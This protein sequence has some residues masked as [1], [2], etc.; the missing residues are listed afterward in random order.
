MKVLLIN[1]PDTA[2]KY[3]FIGLVAPPLGIGYIAAVLEE[4][5]IEVKIIDGSALEMSWEELE[6]EIYT[7]S[8]N[9][10]G[11][12]ALTPT[13]NQALKTARIAK[14]TCNDALV[15][16]GG[17][18]PTFTYN[19]LLKNDFVDI[20]AFGE[21]EYTM[22]ELAKAVENE[23]DLREVK[24]IATKEFVTPSRP[25]IEDL[26]ELPFPARHLLPMDKYKILN[27]KL[28]TGTL[29]SGRGCPHKCSFCS[30]AA[31]HGHKL[32]M[33]SSENIV[34]E[35]E[36]LLNVHD[37]EMMAFMDDTFTMNRKRV[38]EVCA[39]IKERD[40]DFY[41]GCTARA[42]TLNKNLLRKNEGFRMHYSIFRSRI[43]RSA[44][45]R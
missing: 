29:I 40:L 35:M 36:H 28:T 31:M 7:Y 19:E 6:K 33:R 1:P 12:T 38:E 22:L 24:G 15:V 2:S 39:E 21:G 26:D 10:I 30:S 44:T 14:N 41:W 45:F 43:C 37:A 3:K 13:I 20:V 17:Y 42:D 18:H 23:T 11:I 25:I 5:D 16:L 34:D 8:P 9:I 27:M 32:R 4:N